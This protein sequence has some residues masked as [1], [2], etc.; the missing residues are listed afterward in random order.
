MLLEVRLYITNGKGVYKKNTDGS[1]GEL[2]KMHDTPEEAKAHMKALMANVDDAKESA[3]R[4]TSDVHEWVDLTEAT[5]DSAAKAAEV[6]LLASGWSKNNRHYSRAVI[7][8]SAPLFE[9]VKAY[10]NHPSK[11]EIKERPERNVLDAVGV[12]ENVHFDESTGKLK[13]TYRAIGKLGDDLWPWVIESVEGRG[14]PMGLSIHALGTARKGEA[15]GKNGLI[16]EAITHAES[17]D[18]VTAPAAGGSFDRLL[19]GDDSWSRAVINTMTLEE[20]R[21]ARPDLLD[22]LKREWKTTRDSEAIKE[23]RAQA[24]TATSQVTAITQEKQAAQAALTEALETI[25]TFN[26]ERLVDSLLEGKKL[27]DEVRKELRGK[28]LNATD[29]AAMLEVLDMTMAVLGA[30]RLPVR[31][32]GAGRPSSPQSLTPPTPPRHAVAEALGI[33]PALAKAE[34]IDEFLE[35][36]RQATSH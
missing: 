7:K 3:T 23:A 24:D 16:V 10:A 31:I 15:D 34:T 35:A 20:L 4:R 36:R 2:V 28:L 26:K 25:A 11:S 1:Q 21:E 13:A 12:Y 18:F 27:P 33:N 8:A 6:T 9:G 22:S 29:T 17:V 5:I 14:K 32:T 30:V 19:A